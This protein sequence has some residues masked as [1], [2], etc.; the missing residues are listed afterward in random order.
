MLTRFFEEHINF[1][2]CF[3]LRYIAQ[4]LVASVNRLK[5]IKYTQL[6]FS[7]KVYKLNN[8]SVEPSA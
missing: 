1:K 2:F 4:A 8:L 5:P 7:L 6:I 3:C